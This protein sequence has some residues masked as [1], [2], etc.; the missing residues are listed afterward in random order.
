VFVKR[1]W[2]GDRV[3]V[4]NQVLVW[5]RVTLEDEVRRP[6]RCIHERL[7]AALRWTPRRISAHLVERGSIGANATIRC[8]VTGG[9]N[10]FVAAGGVVVRDVPPHALV[11]GNPARRIGWV[12]ACAET[13]GSDFTCRCGRRYRLAADGAA[14]LVPDIP[15]A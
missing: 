12:C 10:A 4:K 15:G 2:I 3:T 7:A 11:A 5:D 9:A 6:R 14:G 13:L 8:G 1:A